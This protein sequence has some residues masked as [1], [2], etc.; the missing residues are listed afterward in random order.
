MKRMGF[1]IVND[2]MMMDHFVKNSRV[3]LGFLLLNKMAMMAGLGFPPPTDGE[4]A[5]LQ[6]FVG[7]R[8]EEYEIALRIYYRKRR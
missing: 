5:S 2:D 6:P 8:D 7:R 4:S 1:H 3:P